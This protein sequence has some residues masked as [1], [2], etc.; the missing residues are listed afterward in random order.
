M[1]VLVPFCPDFS[2]PDLSPFQDR[3]ELYGGFM[4]ESWEAQYQTSYGLNRMSS[5]CQSANF[6]SF[7]Q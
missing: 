3:I 5:F 4:D 6:A 7:R 1:K 2:L